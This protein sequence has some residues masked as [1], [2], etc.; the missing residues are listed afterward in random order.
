MKAVLAALL[1]A[2]GAGGAA[3][4]PH[5]RLACGLT[6]HVAEGRLV[7]VEQRLTLDAASSAALADRVVPAAT[8]PL[9]KPVWQ[10]REL[11]RGLFRQGDWMLA[12]QGS[13]GTAVAL[14]DEAAHWQQQADGRLV[15]TLKLRPA[16]AFA[17]AGELAL[18][19]RDPG[20]YWLAEFTDAAAVQVQGA[21]CQ[22]RFD[23]PRDAQAEAAA[24][25]A[26][27]LAAGVAGAE[28]VS[29]A[30]TTGAPLGAGRALLRCEGAAAPDAARQTVRPPSTGNSTPVMNSAS[31][32]AR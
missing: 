1:L 3:A 23:A 6:L 2:L 31:S 13:D 16:R 19:C 20:W 29:A 9:P 26:A 32:L 8:E 15:V 14:D 4:H 25:Q 21:A 5:G 28:R 24:L 22:A 11:L 30:A 17:A 18:H 12:L 10:F 27:A 7:A